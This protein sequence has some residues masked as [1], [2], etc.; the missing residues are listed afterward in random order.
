MVETPGAWRPWG[1]RKAAPRLPSC[2][3]GKRTRL[4]H[5][6]QNRRIERRTGTL[7][8]ESVRE[9]GLYVSEIYARALGRLDGGLVLDTMMRTQLMTSIRLRRLQ[10]AAVR[11]VIRPAVGHATGAA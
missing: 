6:W 1:L 11:R 4:T 9:R 10:L 8:A 7:R 5:L 2:R 3:R